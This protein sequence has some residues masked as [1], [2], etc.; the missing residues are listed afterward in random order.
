MLIL[1][2][3]IF[4]IKMFNACVAVSLEDFN[5]RNTGDFPNNIYFLY[6]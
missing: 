3:V 6:F 5:E 4:Q 1:E 2:A